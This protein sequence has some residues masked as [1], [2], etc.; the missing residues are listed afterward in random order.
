MHAPTKISLKNQTKM[1]LNQRFTAIMKS[2]PAANSQQSRSGDGNQRPASEKNRR[3]A[4]LMEK[5]TYPSAGVVHDQRPTSSAS[6]KPSVLERLGQRRGGVVP[7][8]AINRG[9]G[10]RSFVRGV[11][12]LGGVQKPF[13]STRGGQR[14]FPY[15]RNQQRGGFVMRGR[16]R[17]GGRGGGSHIGAPA[18]SVSKDELD[19][20]LDSYMSKSK[21]MSV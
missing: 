9:G 5:R 21:G 19:D 11:G 17:G 18:K 10:S 16:G 6:S 20:A 1:T 8:V 2:R 12:R 7:H 3:L 4:Q 14:N 13:P 15:Q